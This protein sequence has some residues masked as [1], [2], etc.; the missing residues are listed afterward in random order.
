MEETQVPARVS[1]GVSQDAGVTRPG[2]HGDL[3][4]K[5]QGGNFTFPGVV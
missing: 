2:G 3:E 1:K 5:L 4:E